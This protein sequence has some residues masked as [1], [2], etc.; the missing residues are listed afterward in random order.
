MRSTQ[1]LAFFV[2]IVLGS[3]VRAQQAPKVE[4]GKNGFL[5]EHESI[6]LG[7]A[8]TGVNYSPDGKFVVATYD[9]N[10]F[11]WDAKT[12]KLARSW[13][14]AKPGVSS[15]AFSPNG[16]RLVGCEFNYGGPKQKTLYFWEFIT[17]KE[18]WS[19]T[20]IG[21]WGVR[22]S[23]SGK[24][25]TIKQ[26]RSHGA[27]I[28]SAKTGQPVLTQF[29]RKN[30]S[31]FDGL[32]V[33]PDDRFIVFAPDQRTLH[34]WDAKNAKLVW[35]QRTKPY[36]LPID[37]PKCFS[38]DGQ[39]LFTQRGVYDF[40][41]WTKL[42]DVSLVAPP[43][44]SPDGRFFAVPS[45]TSIVVFE[46]MT[47][48]VV[49][50]LKGHKVQVQG[51]EFTADGKTLLSRS[52]PE[53]TSIPTVPP[54]DERYLRFWDVEAGKEIQGFDGPVFPQPYTFDVSPD[55][56]HFTASF[57]GSV[58]IWKVPQR[59]VAKVA[60]P[61]VSDE[62]MTKL[63]AVL[64]GKEAKPALRAVQTLARDPKR[65]LPFLRKKLEPTTKLQVERW[66]KD[67]NDDDFH[68]RAKAD[69]ELRAVASTF[70]S[71]IQK[72][73]SE[74]QSAE[75]RK[76]LDSILA[77]AKKQRHPLQKPGTL[78][79][80]RVIAILERIGNDDAKAMLRRFA[81]GTDDSPET[82][83]ARRALHRL[84]PRVAGES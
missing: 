81:R 79:R 60:R 23:P 17:G 62:T 45:F 40:R 82:I 1:L 54:F 34:L 69:A 59:K 13:T 47:G 71:K 10:V 27:R 11:V 22:F 29:Y 84:G 2:L 42:Y 15:L 68:V 37:V 3:P 67:L 73:A 20:G 80:L 9:A 74:A 48:T 76:R 52:H 31:F 14:C 8:F 56:K 39:L 21:G 25:L 51:L 50:T 55:G 64:L 35:T 65:S 77:Q 43:V 57:W 12:G 26:M 63:W 5:L 78:R 53:P 28:Y 46:T 66:L 4:P 72:A 44:F 33:S 16:K 36:A 6:P 24:F 7:R 75:G 58:G 41:T 49:H 83:H 18:A 32:C 30:E 19:Q 61:K 70:A 38:P